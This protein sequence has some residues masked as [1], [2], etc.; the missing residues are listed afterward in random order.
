MGGVDIDIAVHLGSSISFFASAYVLVLLSRL[1][2]TYRAK[3]TMRLMFHMA[4]VQLPMTAARGIGDHS[5]AIPWLCTLQGTL[6]QL[7][8]IVFLLT[9]FFV[10]N[11]YLQICRGWQEL[12]C[13]QLLP[14]Y[15]GAAYGV[16]LASTLAVLLGGD[17]TPA[18]AWC[19]PPFELH[20]W[21]FYVPLG[22]TEIFVVVCMTRIVRQVYKV[23]AS[24]H[25][26]TLAKPTKKQQVEKEGSSHAS[27]LSNRMESAATIAETTSDTA[28]KPNHAPTNNAAAP[29]SPK[30]PAP[31][32][33]SGSGGNTAATNAATNA[34]HGG[35][36]GG[37]SG[38]GSDPLTAGPPPTAAEAAAAAATATATTPSS[39]EPPVRKET[40]VHHQTTA[41]PTVSSLAQTPW[42][43]RRQT[44]VQATRRQAT[45]R[46]LAFS[47]VMVLSWA[48]DC[49]DRIRLALDGKRTESELVEQIQFVTVPL[50]GFWYALIICLPLLTKLQTS[51]TRKPLV[52]TAGL[53]RKA[54]PRALFSANSGGGE[55]PDVEVQMGSVYKTQ[56]TAV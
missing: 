39:V 35:G 49:I 16:G 42:Q 33:L 27:R 55:S 21:V 43:A 53:Q 48:A 10:N 29:R 32:T 23:T 17:M 6:L 25:L 3:T 41:K 7:D 40:M 50:Q 14:L 22:L 19:S 30:T 26:T 2:E 9:A 12:K 24:R 20:V 28:I 18:Q 54:K 51:H 15:L 45:Y 37:S 11:S 31:T 8:V 52:A 4:A 36:G 44:V 47:A 34:M 46:A 13:A 38:S 5:F 56:Q 1:P